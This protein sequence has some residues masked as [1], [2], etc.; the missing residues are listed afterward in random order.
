MLRENSKNFV[1]GIQNEQIDKGETDRLIEN[2]TNQ[3]A[4]RSWR[5]ACWS[6][7]KKP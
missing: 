3:K 6:F 7:K 5:A 2:F 4:D 1:D